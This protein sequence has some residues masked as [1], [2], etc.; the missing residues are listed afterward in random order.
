M[1]DNN[2]KIT[3]QNEFEVPMPQKKNDDITTENTDKNQQQNNQRQNNQQGNKEQ[4]GFK[5]DEREEDEKEIHQNDNERKERENPDNP[6]YQDAHENKD[7]DAQWQKDKINEGFNE[8]NSDDKKTKEGVPVNSKGDAD[9]THQVVEKEAY[10]S[11][12]NK[13]KGS[14]GDTRKDSIIDRPKTE[15]YEDEQK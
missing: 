4:A 8:N 13:E 2:N 6:T 1:P 12:K 11:D 15:T 9:E 14:L 7:K 10:L 5:S 3:N